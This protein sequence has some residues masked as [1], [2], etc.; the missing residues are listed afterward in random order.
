MMEIADLAINGSYLAYLYVVL[1]E[2]SI[3]YLQRP[4][5]NRRFIS[6]AKLSR[7]GGTTS[8]ATALGAKEMRPPFS[9]RSRKYAVSS[10]PQR[11]RFFRKRRLATAVRL[12]RTLPVPP[13][14]TWLLTRAGSVE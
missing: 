6:Q 13:V 8:V 12:R 11:P 14:T 1:L 10:P 2:I 9:I 4:D 3:L 5:L 7:S